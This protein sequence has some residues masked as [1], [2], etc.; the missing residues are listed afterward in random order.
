MRELA[1]TLAGRARPVYVPERPSD[2]EPFW[3]WFNDANARGPI[4]YDTETTGL[5]IYTDRFR[6]RTMQFGD[7][8]QAWVLRTELSEM[9][10]RAGGNALRRAQR[11]I[12][13]N[14]PFDWLVSDRHVPGITLEMLAPK[15][16]DTRIQCKLIDPRSEMEG[17][18]GAAL[19]PVSAYYVDPDAPDT[20][21]GLIEVFH[22]YGRTKDT[23]WTVPEL[24]H[25]PTYLAYGGGDVILVSEVAPILENVITQKGIRPALLK[26]EHELA[27]IGAVMTRT[28]LLVDRP[29]VEQLDG[30]LE[31]DH[32]R[33]TAV[34]ANHGVNNVNSVDQLA[35]G[36]IANGVTLTEKTEKGAWKLDKTT[37]NPLAGFNVKGERLDHIT[38]HPLA[39]AAYHAKRA[40]K[41]RKTYVQRFIEHADSNGR[42]HPSI[43]TLQ[44]R[45][46]RMSITGDLAAQTLPS[47]DSM[48]RR[49]ILAEEGH[50]WF[51][52]DFS[53]VEMRVLAALADVWLMKQ[54]ISEGRDLHD[55]TAEL[56][57]GNA[58]T[59]TQRKIC[60]GIGFGKVYGG[61]LDTL[62]LLSGAPKADVSNA[63]KRYDSVYP[64]ITRASRRWQ[65][66]ARA[67]GF[68]VWTETG[69]P[70]PVD[71]HRLYAVVNYRC[72]SIARDCLGQGLIEIDAAGLLEY[73]RLPI[74]DEVVGSAP[75][76][77]AEEIMHEIE[78]CMTMSLGAVPI[79]AAGE[80]GNRSWGSLYGSSY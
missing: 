79:D 53:A 25:D 7:R 34:A 55:F 52:V 1:F 59:K 2:L 48:I 46:A 75:A 5:D 73:V 26:Y 64:E 19:K 63:L 44:A 56:V 9:L 77:H 47:S 33:W 16:T 27:R 41:W 68:V 43:N 51:S 78:R 6:L 22:R 24:I 11:L 14:A 49:A 28:G 8:E 32:D 35:Q 29:Y 15:T 38:P 18:I 57:Y 3:D 23:G 72:Q 20:Q 71:Q 12:I 65:R 67:N 60:K 40:G 30:E 66:E 74:H 50:R 31:R 69:R 54:A 21:N 61:G 62:V 58:F 39:E 36:L 70:L 45:T 17:G 13:H 80:V 42:I 10:L 37:L 4:G 76:Q